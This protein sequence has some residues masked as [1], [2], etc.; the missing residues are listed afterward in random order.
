MSITSWTRCA[1]TETLARTGSRRYT[2]AET[3]AVARKAM[4]DMSP[5]TQSAYAPLVAMLPVLWLF[6]SLGVLK[7]STPV[8]CAAGLAMSAVL[9]VAGWGFT[10]VLAAKAFLDG[11]A[12]AVMPILWVIF[13]ALLTYSIAVETKAMDC[14]KDLLASVSRDRRIQALLIAWG[15]GG[16]MESVA[17]FGTAVA[18][19]AAVLVS[20]G[21]A[22]FCAA[23]V[24]LLA[25]T[26]AVAFGV[27][28]I[29][30]ITLAW[31][32]DLPVTE[33]STQIVLQLTAFVFIVPIFIVTAVTGSVRGVSGVWVHALGAGA[34]FGVVQFIAARY[35]GPEMPAI[36]G[37]L[38]AFATTAA[39][40]KYL[41]PKQIWTFAHD[42]EESIP[43]DGKTRAGEAG[44]REQA[45]EARL[46]LAAQ[47]KAWSPYIVLLILV[48]ASRMIE[49]VNALLAKATSLHAIYDGPG[50]KPLA[51]AWLLTPGTLVLTA[52]LIGGRIQGASFGA[53]LRLSGKTARQMGKSVITIV[54][55]VVLAKM[56]GYSGMVNTVAVALADIA[57][58]FYPLVAPVL[59]MLGTF[60]TGSD[61]S[62]NI[63]F[64]QLQKQVAL[65]IGVSPI[66]IAAANTSGACIG[67]IISLQSI[68]IAGISANIAGREGELLI[69][70]VKYALPFIVALGALVFAVA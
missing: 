5:F 41:P 15:F 21:F 16:F 36:L 20:L 32:T 68:A 42:G 55:I 30:V 57:G 35:I 25:N 62:S 53:I 50:G 19:P 28:G 65:T 56:L 33:L 4:T 14:I 51:V 52:A 31:I 66:W 43:Q 18:V 61:T 58:T 63:L 23:V 8:A 12:F 44:P 27:V 26:V 2:F 59:G 46:D 34:S 48:L 6:V 1:P 13:A 10:P 11:A 17:G 29:P 64:G 54:C 3:I 22:P 37:S 69:V 40:A 60:I 67:K 39:L 70:C 9:A 24:C 7:M 38:A 47:L 45:G 49:P